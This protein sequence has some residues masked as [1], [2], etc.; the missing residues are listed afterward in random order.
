MSLCSQVAMGRSRGV[1][2]FAAWKVTRCQ[3]T[4]CE[5]G[6]HVKRRGDRQLRGRASDT[7]P[8]TP[9]CFLQRQPWPRVW[10]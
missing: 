3:M 6:D 10:C 5:E 2:F 1:D 7:V 8:A 9:P 4:E